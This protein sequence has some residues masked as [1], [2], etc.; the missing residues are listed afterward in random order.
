MILNLV[1]RVTIAIAILGVCQFSVAQWDSTEFT[2][3]YNGSDI[4]DGTT[5]VSPWAIAGGLEDDDLSLNGSTL[6]ITPLGGADGDDNNGWIQQDGDTTP[7]ETPGSG[8]VEQN[9]WALEFA[10]DLDDLDLSVNDNITLWAEGGGNRQII[11][12][13][14]DSVSTFGGTVLDMNDNTDGMHVF[15]LAFSALDATAD[16]SGTYQ[17]YRDGVLIGAD[18]PRESGQGL[19]RLIIGDCCTSLGNPVDQYNIGYVRFSAVPEPSSLGILMIG[20]LGLFG[21][22]R[23]K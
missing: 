4:F 7:W 12:I 6:T 1:S 17:L 13:G 10:L 5:T 19:S 3:Q 15:Q 2:Y 8:V 22:V 16:A 9:E 14:A 11:V 21:R 18:L 23:R 20:M